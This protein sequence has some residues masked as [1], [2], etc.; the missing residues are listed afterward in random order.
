MSIYLSSIDQD[1]FGIRTAKVH[2]V[3]GENY[4]QVQQFCQEESVALCIARVNVRHLDVVQSMEAD[5]YRLMDTLVYYTFKYAKKEIPIDT[6]KH[7][8]RSAQAGDVDAI[9]VI[10]RD[11]FKGYYGH[12]HADP[13][14][15]NDLCDAVYTD[16]AMTSAQSKNDT[17]EILVVDY[18]GM[19]QGFATLRQ[20][21][22][23]EGEGVLFGVA[24]Q[25]QG[26]GIYKS[27]MIAGMRWCLQQGMEQMIVS[28]QIT[29]IA[30]QKVWARLGFEVAY[31]YYTLHKWY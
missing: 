27:M 14:L 2:D 9:S 22:P 8:I 5:G 19:L 12:Y 1:R 26:Q 13:R 29:N 23:V 11:S 20:N 18:D 4:K 31:G 24:P 16:W 25:A 30:V 10:A 7:V 15:D 3:N 6:N 21:S 28:T 17:D